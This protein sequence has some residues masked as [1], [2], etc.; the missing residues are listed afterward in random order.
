MHPAIRHCPPFENYAK[1]YFHTKGL[2][3]VF[4]KG[5]G[6]GMGGEIFGALFF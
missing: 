1:L 4:N 2:E 5:G 3:K 6:G